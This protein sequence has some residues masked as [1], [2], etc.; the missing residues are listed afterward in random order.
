MMGDLWNMLSGLSQANLSYLGSALSP[1]DSPDAPN[2]SGKLFLFCCFSCRHDSAFIKCK[3]W[4]NICSLKGISE[5]CITIWNYLLSGGNA[6]VAWSHWPQTLGGSYE[7]ISRKSYN[8][9]LLFFCCTMGY[10]FYTERGSVVFTKLLFFSDNP[11]IHGGCV[12]IGS[13]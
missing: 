7:C 3:C 12:C 4:Y 5:S 8:C 13:L 2:L 10:T 6:E 1:H 11:D 9:L